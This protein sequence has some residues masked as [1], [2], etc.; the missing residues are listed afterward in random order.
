MP[1]LKGKVA[2]TIADPNQFE[3]DFAVSEADIFSVKTGQSATIT[4]DALTGDTFQAKITAIAP[5]ATISSGVVSYIVT[6]TLTSLI[7][8]NTTGSTG[9]GSSPSSS[10]TRPTALPSGVIPSN[11]PTNRPLAS[12]LA[13]GTLPT[14]LPAAILQRLQGQGANSNSSAATGQAVS[15]KQG[16]TSEVTIITQQKNNVLLVP[17]RAITTS[18]GKA[19][20]NWLPALPL[21]HKW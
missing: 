8:I 18:G 2:L 10:F 20:C 1:A 4:V 9:S 15:L 12:A 3:V 19:L 21:R 11:F 13:S 17:N 16:L 5:T 6:A 14:D 7:P